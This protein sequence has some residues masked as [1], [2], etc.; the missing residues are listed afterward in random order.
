MPVRVPQGGCVLRFYVSL[1]NRARVEL[2]LHHVVRFSESLF[3]V[4]LLVHEAVGDVA[5]LVGFFAELGGDHVF[6]E[7]L[8]VVL[9]R[10]Q[11]VGTG[12]QDFVLHLDQGGRFLGDVGGIGGDAG[13]GMAAEQGLGA[14]EDIVAGGAGR[15]GRVVLGGDG[16]VGARN[17]RADA[18]QRL[19]RGS[20]DG[21]D[22]SVGVGTAQHLAEQHP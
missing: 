8:G 22:A 12:A 6:V 9:H 11:H 10:V 21:L 18:G 5:P 19:G 1:V 13:D 14:G 15:Q 2:A 7:Q 17:H 4:A 20:V 3:H 16:Q